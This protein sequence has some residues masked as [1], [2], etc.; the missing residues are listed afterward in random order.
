MD[1]RL[2][3]QSVFPATPVPASRSLRLMLTGGRALV[4]REA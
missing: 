3:R 1:E 4:S 2:P